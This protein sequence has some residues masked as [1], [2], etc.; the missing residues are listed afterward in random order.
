MPGYEQEAWVS[1]QHYQD[2]TWNELVLFWTA[3]NR[4]LLHMMERTP[5]QARS[6]PCRI[7]KGDPVTLEFLMVDY[8]RHLQRHLAQIMK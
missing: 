1:T 2:R 5:E 8:V 4:H 6:F 7:G 3:Y